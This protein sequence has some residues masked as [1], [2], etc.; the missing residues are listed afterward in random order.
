[1]AAT[2]MGDG[3]TMMGRIVM[4]AQ[5]TDSQRI[6]GLETRLLRAENAA[7][8]LTRRVAALERENAN[9]RDGL[10]SRE[11]IQEEGR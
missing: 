1:M 4:S 9:L 6:D 3:L 7:F 11:R 2:T 5:M 10:V 8:D